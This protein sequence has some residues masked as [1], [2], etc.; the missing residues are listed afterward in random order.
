M[1]TH[2]AYNITGKIAVF[3]QGRPQQ[4][5]VLQ[6]TNTRHRYPRA[7]I[8]SISKTPGKIRLDI[9]STLCLAV[10]AFQSSPFDIIFFLSVQV[11]VQFERPW[12]HS[13]ECWSHACY[14]IAPLRHSQNPAAAHAL[15]D[16]LHL[17]R[18]AF[19]LLWVASAKLNYSS[20]TDK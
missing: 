10:G 1:N 20:I 14:N 6:I 19:R 3:Q 15:S 18:H 5:T 12:L 13:S 17:P 9:S 16:G 8:P 11:I 7:V 2:N 4:T